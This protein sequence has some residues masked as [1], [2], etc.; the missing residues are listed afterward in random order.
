MLFNKNCMLGDKY[1]LLAGNKSSLDDEESSLVDK[2]CSLVGQSGG[3]FKYLTYFYGQF[4]SKCHS[5]IKLSLCPFVYFVS[6]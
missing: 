4:K 2:K 1:G 5:L 3:F 6:L